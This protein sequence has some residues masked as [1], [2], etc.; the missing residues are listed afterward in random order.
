MRTHLRIELENADVLINLAGRSVVC[1]YT[2]ANRRAIKESR[3]QTTHL[4][5]QAI[6]HALHARR[7]WVKASTATIYR[8]ALE[9][10]QN[11]I[12][13]FM[14]RFLDALTMFVTA[15]PSS[16]EGYRRRHLQLREDLPGKQCHSLLYGGA[17][18]RE[19]VRHP[20]HLF[21]PNCLPLAQASRED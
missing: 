13:T 6:G 2:P 20:L 1:R 16:E 21:V 12:R 9:E 10:V 17:M 7:L 3:I 11:F 18:T 5:G 8:Q 19:R 4:L 15:D 14:K